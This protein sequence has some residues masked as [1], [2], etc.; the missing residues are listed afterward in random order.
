MY[1]LIRCFV[2]HDQL[3]IHKVKAVGLSLEGICYHVIDWI[4]DFSFSGVKR[5]KATLIYSLK[6]S[7]RG[8]TL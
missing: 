5:Q 7:E 4:E 2:V 3:V 6:S 1:Y 8:G